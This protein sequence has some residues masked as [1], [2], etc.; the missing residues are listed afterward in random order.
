LADKKHTDEMIGDALREAGTLVIVFACLYTL[1][2]KSDNSTT[3][4][5]T[6]VL[7]VI[8]GVAFLLFGINVER[9]RQ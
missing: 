6:F 2:E 5:V 4:W 9:S 8:A 7:V 3:N 1:L